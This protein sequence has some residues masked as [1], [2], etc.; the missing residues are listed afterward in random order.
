MS[1][2][3]NLM[4]AEL[5]PT[6]LG[7]HIARREKLW[8]EREIQVN[9]VGPPEKSDGYKK[10]PKQNRREVSGKVCPKPQGGRPTAFA[11]DTA[12]KTGMSKRAINLATSRAKAIPGDIRAIIK[13]TKL[14]RGVYLDSLKGMEPEEQRAKLSATEY[15]EHLAKR[16]ELWGLREVSGK[17][18]PKP[19]GGRPEGF[20]SDTA[21][22]TGVSKRAVNLATSRA[23][24]IPGDI[25]AIIKGTKLDTGVYL[26]SLK[27][28]EPEDQRAKV[29]GDLA[30]PP[31]PKLPSPKEARSIARATSCLV[32][33]SDDHYYSGATEEEGAEHV[34]LREQTYSVIDAIDAIVGVGVSPKQWCEEVKS[35]WVVRL[36]F[37]RLETATHWLAELGPELIRQKLLF[38]CEVKADGEEI[39]R[40]DDDEQQFEALKRSW[41][42]ASTDA[43]RRIRAWVA[44]QQTP[45]SDDETDY[46]RAA[47]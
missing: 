11:A 31:K 5:N 13:G 18:C 19:Q 27:G 32:L 3:P 20:A 46:D 45:V 17:V 39:I 9:Q 40:I 10:P 4:R 41:S 2:A 43:R 16:E 8:A 1:S 38:D 28:M 42:A 21:A 7:E 15:T 35:H 12:E 24:A 30:E 36:E 25:R 33:A 34:R 22:K 44:E 23:K 14:D 37:G 47:S 26:D 29:R 6:E